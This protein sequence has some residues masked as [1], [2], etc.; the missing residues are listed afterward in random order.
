LDYLAN[1]FIAR[2]WS[3]KSLHR[4]M[5]LS[6]TYRQSSVAR[7]ELASLDPVN[8]FLGRQNRFRLEAEVIRD[9]NLAV[10]GLL[11]DK[12]GGPSVRPPLPKGVAELGYANSV[13]W[14]ESKGE[15]RFRR[16]L[17]IFFQRTVPYPML[18]TFDSPDGNVTCPK[19][20]RSNTPLQALT[21]LNDP[22]FIECAQAFGRRII[23]EGPEEVAG[24]VRW[25]FRLALTREPSEAE[26][27]RLVK[28]HDEIKQLAA[29]D[30][31][32]AA[33]LVGEYAPDGVLVDDAAAWVAVGRTLLNL[34]EFVTRE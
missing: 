15:D 27:E 8:A 7:A 19:R 14:L 5:V 12:L 25:A 33:R 11:A 30:T 13:K 3:M 2:G 34:D 28:L 10:S 20:E 26:T 31:E 24:R 21:L 1:E 22:V 4:Q 17:Y 6:A 9:L 18:T 32:S 16:G 23:E 29:E